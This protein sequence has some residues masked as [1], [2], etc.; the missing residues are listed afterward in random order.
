MFTVVAL[1]TFCTQPLVTNQRTAFQGRLK[2]EVKKVPP[3]PYSNPIYL[4]VK[5]VG[6]C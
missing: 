1:T 5:T 6:N 3:T 4:Q 2:Q